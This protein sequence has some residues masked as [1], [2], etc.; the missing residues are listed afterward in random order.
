[1][2]TKPLRSIAVAAVLAAVPLFGCAAARSPEPPPELERARTTIR[3]AET[4]GAEVE[5]GAQV[6]LA[7]AR[8]HLAQAERRL[9]AGDWDGARGLLRR[10]EADA[11]V[12]L[13]VAREAT[14][15]DAARRTLEQTSLIADG[16][17]P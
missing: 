6:Y 12:A 4:E 17:E 10:A 11:E 7:L 13:L 14:L 3:T 8:D 15:R 1:M 5:R 2:R 9:A 16:G